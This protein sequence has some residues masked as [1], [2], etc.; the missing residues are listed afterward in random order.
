LGAYFDCKYGQLIK[1][2]KKEGKMCKIG[3]L[4]EAE[5]WHGH[6]SMIQVTH[7]NS[8]HMGFFQY[9]KNLE[10]WFEVHNL[11]ETKT[12]IQ[13][14]ELGIQDLPL[15][16]ELHS[17]QD[18]ALSEGEWELTWSQVREHALQQFSLPTWLH[19]IMQAWQASQDQGSKT[20]AAWVTDFNRWNSIVRPIA[21]EDAISTKMEALL[22]RGGANP[23]L[24]VFMSIR[25]YRVFNPK[26]THGVPTRNEF[27]SYLTHGC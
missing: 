16:Q 24:N 9:L 27:L 6:R 25:P 15:C 23:E 1:D 17:V 21:S 26:A 14:L 18:E 20:A 2:A 8:K 12:R 10:H 11:Y 13:F 7:A 3:D 19:E 4:K 5:M 22:L